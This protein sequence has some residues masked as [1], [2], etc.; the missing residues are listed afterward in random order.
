M[1]VVT[2][3]SFK[4]GSGRTMALV[5]VGVELARAGRRVLLVDFDL[6]APGLDTFNL[7]RPQSDVPGLVD[8]VSE[9]LHTGVAPDF[10]SFAYKSPLVGLDKGQ[11]WIMPSGKQDDFYARRLSSI[12]WRELYEKKDGYLLFENL[13]SQWQAVLQPD[14]VLIDSRTGHTDVGGIC[15]RHLP[16]SVVVLFFPNEQN[17]R[18]LEKVVKE[19]RLEETGPRK[20]SIQLHFVIA[21]VPDLD[22]EEQILA[23]MIKR[24]KNSLAYDELAAVI[25]HY[26]SLMLLNQSVFTLDRP[27]SRLAQEYRNL[28]NAIK[29][30]NAED[31]EGALEFLSGIGSR[32]FRR[33]DAT[34]AGVVETRI[35]AI[36]QRH[37]S[38][39][40]VLR[41]LARVRRRQHR[42]DE[43]IALLDQATA[44][45]LSDAELLLARAELHVMKNNNEAAV[46]DLTRVL[47]MSEV[48]DLQVSVAVR[49][50]ADLDVP[51]LN[52]LPS[53]LALSTLDFEAQLAV[54]KELFFSRESLA[55][56]VELL[57]SV[58]LRHDLKR[59]Q[60]DH[61]KL[62]LS[63]CLIGL[64]H[65][66]EAMTTISPTRPDPK[67]LDVPDAF[68]YAMAE[69]GQTKLS[70]TDLFAR[71]VELDKEE[72][73][74]GPN[75]DQCL[76]IAL[77]AI[78]DSNKASQ[79]LS[80]ARQQ[81]MTLPRLEFSAWRYLR[82]DPAQFMRD[83]DAIDEMIHGGQLLPEFIQQQPVQSSGAPR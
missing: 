70:P 43:A 67:L 22:D 11:L 26:N 71:V 66:Q 20:K 81:M 60:H 55:V 79:R 64:G 33:K 15:T 59:H 53:S 50:L 83:L 77:H 16:D 49:L 12:D 65:F 80:E 21:N 2:F 40:E 25:H 45:G 3:Y 7:P 75:Y 27:N 29:R 69:W 4:G 41:A 28:T 10:E 74:S 19:I 30:S 8:Y 36:Q 18:G 37:A 5:N 63:L 38:D 57:R 32:S 44:A 9:Y 1:Q 23:G 76:S 17:R 31:R 54:S 48:T 51:I 13:K 73:Q 35:E 61:V 34:P 39:G 58:A 52:R 46:A 56:A 47:E 82:V 42:I 72:K 24:L 6:E 78:G 68:N 62:D 14:Y